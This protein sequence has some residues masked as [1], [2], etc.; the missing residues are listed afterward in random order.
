MPMYQ[1]RSPRLLIQAD[2]YQSPQILFGVRHT[3]LRI[4]RTYLRYRLRGLDE[5]NS[6][7]PIRISIYG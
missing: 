5:T 1:H 4:G 2:P 7:I 3:V 6:F